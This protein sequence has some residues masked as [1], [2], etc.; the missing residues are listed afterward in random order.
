[1]TAVTLDE[2]FQRQVAARGGKVALRF[3]NETVTYNELDRRASQIAHGLRERGIEA[4]DRVAYLGKNSLAYL[5]YLLGAMKAHAVAV[6]VNWRLAEPEIRF[7]LDNSRARLVLAE[8]QFDALAAS[9]APNMPRLVTGGALDTF[10]AWRDRQRTDATAAVARWEEPVLQ[11]YTSG[12]TGRPK[13][14]VLTHQSLLGLRSDPELLPEWYRWSCDDVSLIAMPVAHISGTGWALWTLQAGATGIISREFDPNAVFD[15]MVRNRINKVMLVPTALQIA[16]RHP[17]APNTDFSFLRYVYYGGAPLPEALLAECQ[18]VFRCGFVQ[19][20]GMTETSGTIVALAPEDHDPANGARLRSV[21]KALPGVE[22]KIIDTAGSELPAGSSGEIATRSASNMIGYFEMAPATAETIDAAGW[23]RTGDVGYLD[24]DGYLYLQ[25][26]AKDLIISGGENIYPAEVENAI[27]GHPAVSEVTVVGVPD[28]KW[29][30][31]VKAV[32]V[33]AAGAIPDEAGII[34]WAAERIARYKLPKSVDFVS[35][36][37]RNHT[38][39]V[40][41]RELRDHYRRLSS[42][43]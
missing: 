28:E 37:P 15:Q 24:Q 30:E 34:A 13:G 41:R 23:L 8:S 22:L 10:A 12:T 3:E 1:M 16:V 29:G 25:D 14:A 19:M 2:L 35:A 21:G 4:G 11:L 17:Q 42:R 9:V 18:A 27:Y 40:L 33:L 43:H 20:Y 31:V 7:V 36:L 32:V 5:E 26:R 38:G 39:K 6:P